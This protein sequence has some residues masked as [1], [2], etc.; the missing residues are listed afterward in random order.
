MHSCLSSPQNIN[1]FNCVRALRS[2][3]AILIVRSCVCVW[4]RLS[5]YGNISPNWQIYDTSYLLWEP[6]TTIDETYLYLY[7]SLDRYLKSSSCVWGFGHNPR[8]PSRWPKL[9]DFRGWKES[10]G[11]I[12]WFLLDIPSKYPLYKVYMGL[13]IK[14]TIRKVPPFSVSLLIFYVTT[15]FKELFSKNGTPAQ[16]FQ[17]VLAILL[18]RQWPYVPEKMRKPVCH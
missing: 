9:N 2:Y 6:E 3:R 17:G 16:V 8:S 4:G 5:L 18:A 15:I 13:I 10:V 14:G 7:Q 12:G 11:I 1:L